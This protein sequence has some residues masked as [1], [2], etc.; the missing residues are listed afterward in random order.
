MQDL[1]D[2]YGSIAACSYGPWQILYVAAWELG[3]REHPLYLWDGYI[4]II[5]VLAKLN[6]IWQGGADT[7]DKILD[8]YNSGTHKDKIVPESYINRFWSFYNSLE[9]DE[10]WKPSS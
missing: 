7:V 10:S 8:A 5:W 4:S 9:W 2:T 6:K 1:L 3:Y